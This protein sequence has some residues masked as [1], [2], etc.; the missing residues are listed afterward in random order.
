M[1][2]RPEELQTSQAPPLRHRARD[3]YTIGAA[4]VR[5]LGAEL[6]DP[7]KSQLHQ[8]LERVG[9]SVWG[10]PPSSE[11][12]ITPQTEYLPEQNDV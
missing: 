10:I 6:T 11:P 9:D 1:E 2:S 3:E 7:E 4:S 8:A 5:V 12:T